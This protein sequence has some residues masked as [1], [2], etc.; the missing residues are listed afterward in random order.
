MGVNL[1]FL[2]RGGMVW[3]QTDFCI[4]NLKC[5]FFPFLHYFELQ[6]TKTYLNVPA[7]WNFFLKA[8]I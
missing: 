6:I 3:G 4:K 7:Q 5:Q 1:D 2:V 8:K